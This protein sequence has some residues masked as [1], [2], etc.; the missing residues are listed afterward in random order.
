M[1]RTLTALETDPMSL[2]DGAGL[3]CQAQA[4]ERVPRPGQLDWNSPRLQLVGLHYSDIR[5]DKGLLPPLVQRGA[6]K[7][8]ID[9][10]CAR[11]GVGAHELLGRISG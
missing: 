6:M 8:L 3:G 11:R 10:R 7:T 9:L 2:A 1:E 4:V 5:P